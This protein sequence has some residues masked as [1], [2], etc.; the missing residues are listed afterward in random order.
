MEMFVMRCSRQAIRKF[1]PL[2]L[3]GSLLGIPMPALAADVGLFQNVPT[4]SITSPVVN[5]TYVLYNGVL[6]LY[7]SGGWTSLMPPLAQLSGSGAPTV[8]NDGTEGYGPGSLWVDVT[9]NE[10]FFC[11]SNATGAAVWKLIS[12]GLQSADIQ[13]KLTIADYLSDWL[14]SGLLGTAPGSGLTMVTPSG[15]AVAGGNRIA[16]SGFSY[17]YG[18]SNDTY[19]YILSSGSFNHIALAN[20]APAPTGQPGLLLQK[21]VSG[22]SAITSVTQLAPLCP[23]VV[24]PGNPQQA[25]F[26]MSGTPSAQF[27]NASKLIGSG[28]INVNTAGGNTTISLDGS[29]P[30]TGGTNT[31]SNTQ[32]FETAPVLESNSIQT[33]TGNSV[34]IPDATD[35]LVNTAGEQTLQNKTLT[36]PTITNPTIVTP[37]ITSPTITGTAS[38]GTPLTSG[39]VG[40]V[41]KRQVYTWEVNDGNSLGV[42]GFWQ[43]MLVPGRAGT[44]TQVS[45]FTNA[46][47]S[48]S[49]ACLF[50]GTTDGVDG[51]NILASSPFDLSTLVAN[52][53]MS[54]P[55]TTLSS[56]L[57]ISATQ[58]IYLYISSGALTSDP[59][60]VVV[61]LEFQPDDY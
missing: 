21:V 51:F 7:T 26:L 61:T 16:S 42:S 34:S 38:F 1:L 14:V 25:P 46:I 43:T 18:A 58:P 56:S 17:T 31:F 24:S 22:A 45:I 54:I 27:P 29:L 40:N 6:Y 59:N 36:A 11:I 53:A 41:S 49:G 10:I 12:G 4:S 50:Y 39:N 30:D 32:T 52:T 2:L 35:N 13:P 23:T 3:A 47:A 28:P 33:S 37:T 60:L 15:V 57:H 8:S 48:P 5:E 44:I 20:G 9:D 55:L 19:D